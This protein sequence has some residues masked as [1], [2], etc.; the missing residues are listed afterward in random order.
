MNGRYFKW[1]PFL[2]EAV[3]VMLVG[4]FVYTGVVKLKGRETFLSQLYMNPLL[5]GYQDILSW[6][7]PLSELLIALLLLFP[8]TRRLGLLGAGI[9]MG[10]FTIYVAW[11][12]TVLPHLPCS[13]GGIISSLSWKAHL[14]LNS[15]LT[16]LSLGIYIRY[17]RTTKTG[18][19]V[20][21]GSV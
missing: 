7:V 2:A 13:C 10:L 8:R 19:E 16:V 18:S 4:L 17:P 15:I 14:W 1:F 21:P 12:M 6:A 5:R 3:S 9:L 11:M 20:L